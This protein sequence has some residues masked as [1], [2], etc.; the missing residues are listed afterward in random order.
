MSNR[1]NVTN[2]ETSEIVYAI[3]DMILSE[4]LD[5]DQVLEQ[6][7]AKFGNEFSEEVIKQVYQSV[8]L[9]M[10]ELN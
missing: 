9:D 10:P 4:E 7:I 6:A 8:L 1:Y 3:T 2:Q 5:V